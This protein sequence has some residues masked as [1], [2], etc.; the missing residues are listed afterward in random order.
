LVYVNFFIITLSCQVSKVS[1]V[2]SVGQQLSLMC[3]GQDVRGNIKLSLKATLPTPKKNLVEC[4]VDVASQHLQ[5]KTSE[6]VIS[7]STPPVIIRSA[8]EC[9]SHDIANELLTKKKRSLKVSKYYPRTSSTKGNRKAA[10]KSSIKVAEELARITKQDSDVEAPKDRFSS[11]R[12]KLG[13]VM[14]AEVHQIRA[15]GLV[16]KLRD[17]ERGMYKFQV[18][19][20]KRCFHYY[21]FWLRKFNIRPKL[22]QTYCFTTKMLNLGC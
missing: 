19:F 2:I 20:I 22:L 3:I 12:M 8:E 15:H 16:L 18:W 6:D 7:S 14:T 9:D 21:F 11:S 5:E 4:P 13:D 10:P 1:D 17:G